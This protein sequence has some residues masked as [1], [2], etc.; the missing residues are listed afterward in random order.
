MADCARF[1]STLSETM[2]DTYEVVEVRAILS[3]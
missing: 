2:S 1:A 3:G